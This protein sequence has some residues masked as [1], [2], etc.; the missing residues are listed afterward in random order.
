M[1]K[2]FVSLIH[3][4]LIFSKQ[5]PLMKKREKLEDIQVNIE[6]PSRHVT[7]TMKRKL[8]EDNQVDA[9]KTNVVHVLLEKQISTPLKPI[10]DLLQQTP[11]QIRENEAEKRKE[12]YLKN[13]ADQKYF[14]FYVLNVC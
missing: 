11:H 4:Y 14:N 9:K 8:Q 13:K 12:I 5:S 1:Y 7:R 3:I 2:L 6:E 10:D